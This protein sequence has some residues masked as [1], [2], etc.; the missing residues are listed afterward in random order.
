MG[1]FSASEMGRWKK[2]HALTMFT[3]LHG[4]LKPPAED[5]NGYDS[6]AAAPAIDGNVKNKKIKKHVQKRYFM[7]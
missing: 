4:A 7:L 2:R 6:Q 5:A 1:I 3:Y